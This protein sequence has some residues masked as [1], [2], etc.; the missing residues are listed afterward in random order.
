[1]EL[2]CCSMGLDYC[3]AAPPP[4]APPTWGKWQGLWWSSRGV[5]GFHKVRLGHSCLSPFML[6]CVWHG[7]YSKS[8]YV[9]LRYLYI[10][11]FLRLPVLLQSELL[12]KAISIVIHAAVVGKLRLVFIQRAFALSCLI[13]NILALLFIFR[14]CWHGSL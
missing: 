11:R 1:M 9:P 7:N 6:E 8:P 12:L 3:A 13:L 4:P 10:P 5:E 2:R 14:E